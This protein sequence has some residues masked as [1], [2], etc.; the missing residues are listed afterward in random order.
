M[1]GLCGAT[2]LF[3]V[4]L[5]WALVFKAGLGGKGAA[6]AT[7]ISQW[8]NLFFLFLYVKLSGKCKRTWTGFST[9]GLH[10]IYEFVSIAVPSAAMIWWVDFPSM[11]SQESLIFL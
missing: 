2:A 9:E 4:P 11:G 6:L 7:A 10:E 8:I 1:V 3:H 5:C